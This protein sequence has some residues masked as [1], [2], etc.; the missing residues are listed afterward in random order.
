MTKKK[1]GTFMPLLQV[2]NV[3]EHIYKRIVQLAEM[4]RRSIAQETL[5]LLENA[6]GIN[7]SYK[8]HREKL[9]DCILKENENS[10]LNET[11][12]PVQLVREDRER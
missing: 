6:L 5:S 2:R 12:D 1:G 7:N 9:I 10:Y 11:L 3:P 4:E 8:T